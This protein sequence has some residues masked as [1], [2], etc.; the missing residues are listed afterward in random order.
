MGRALAEAEPAASAVFAEADQILGAPLSRLC[1]E[2]P[3]S[4]LSDT[5]NTQPAL[6]VHSVA[7]LRALEARG[8]A[9]RPA[10][11]AGHSLGEFSALVAAGS[12]SFPEALRLVR[13][14][15]RV[16]KEAGQRQP[17]GM[18][19]VLGLDVDIVDAACREAREATGSSVEVANDNCPGQVVI[20]GS[21]AALARAAER[22]KELGARR[23]IRLAVS[24]AA[25][26]ALMASAQEVFRPTLAGAEVAEPR[27]VVIGNVHAEPLRTVLDIRTDLEAQLTSRV[28]WTESVR[29]MVGTG[30]T[31]FFELGTGEVLSGLIRRTDPAVQV[32]AL[33][34]PSSYIPLLG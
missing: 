31:A 7:V 30:V 25:H 34:T 9:S 17:G 23:V 32:H 27:V 22:L 8:L 29:S 24:I 3:E 1:W 11:V 15:G 26:S 28:R 6:L 19:A 4:D 21:E 33:D 2:G 20:S 12:L 16:M 13:E 10:F 14:R 5:V 18:A